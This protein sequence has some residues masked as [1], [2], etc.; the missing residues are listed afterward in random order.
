MGTQ[1]PMVCKRLEPVQVGVMDVIKR[2]ICMLGKRSHVQI[3]NKSTSY[4]RDRSHLHTRLTFI[5]HKL[6]ATPNPNQSVIG[7]NA[8]M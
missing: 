6:Y 4:D 8:A 5:H 7:D 1:F 3:G 2:H